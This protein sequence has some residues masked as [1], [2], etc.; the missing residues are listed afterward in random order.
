[1]YCAKWKDCAIAQ[2]S[3]QNCESKGMLLKLF[4]V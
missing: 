4:L 3:R 1:M 2:I